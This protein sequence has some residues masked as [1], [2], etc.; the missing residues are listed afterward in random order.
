[1]LPQ[2]HQ[3]RAEAYHLRCAVHCELVLLGELLAHEGVVKGG[4]CSDDLESLLFG[5]ECACRRGESGVFHGSGCG[6]GLE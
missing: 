4:A 6:F 1:M 3:H 2:S 5:C